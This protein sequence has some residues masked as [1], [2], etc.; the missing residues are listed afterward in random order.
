M[1]KT[2]VQ[3]FVALLKYLLECASCYNHEIEVNGVRIRKE[4]H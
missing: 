3:V 2:I 4:G 1:D